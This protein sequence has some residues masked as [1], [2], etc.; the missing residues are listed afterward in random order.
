MKTKPCVTVWNEY[1]HEKTDEKVQAIY[2]EG[3]HKA[4][5][6]FLEEAGFTTQTATLDQAEHG[7]TDDVLDKTDVL[8][9]WG[10]MAHS[11]VQETVVDRVQQRILDGMG[12]IVLHSAHFSK[13]FK[14]MM[15]TTCNLRWRE[16]GEKERVWTVAKGHPIANG[17]G[18]Y[19]ELPHTEMYGEFF[20]IPEPDVLVF[21]S[22]F[23]G[24][25]V[26]RSGCCWQRGLG[27]V[28]YFAP[29]HETFP[30]YD[31]K[32]VQQVIINACEWAAAHEKSEVSFGHVPE[33]LEKLD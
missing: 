26:F 18:Q 25:D 3:I 33:P 30:I 4:I 27:R 1:R 29:G 32:N 21:V 19:F 7:L 20:D 6:A 8:V 15:G 12:L 28:F 24:G 31:D 2:P 22:W 14:R 17:I 10:H 23:A 16:I 9:W 5:A 13:I 11:E